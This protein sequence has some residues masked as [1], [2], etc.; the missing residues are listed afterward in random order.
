MHFRIYVKNREFIF[1]NLI[2]HPHFKNK[3]WNMFMLGQPHVYVSEYLLV[4]NLWIRQFVLSN[5][6]EA[7]IMVRAVRHAPTQSKPLSTFW[8]KR[9]VTGW[10]NDTNI[11]MLFRISHLSREQGLYKVW[12]M[13]NLV[14]QLHKQSCK[15]KKYFNILNE[16]SFIIVSPRQSGLE[17]NWQNIQ[18]QLIWTAGKVIKAKWNYALTAVGMKEFCKVYF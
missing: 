10:F 2:V 1:L 4:L 15:Q 7:A 18:S 11:Y 9:H 5:V 8:R 3:S 13:H 17:L 16:T 12:K 14:L 6:S